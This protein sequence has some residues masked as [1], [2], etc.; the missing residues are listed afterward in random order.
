M[1]RIPLVVVGAGVAGAAAAIEAAKAGVQVT[2]IDENPIDMYM[3]A[4]DAPQFFG[5]R[6]MPTLR[7]KAVMLERIVSSN[8]ELSR[9]QEAGVDVRLG[10]YVWGSFR[11]IET[12]RLLD[13]PQL[14]LADGERS[15][16]IG[17]DR[18]IV[19]SGSRDLG[20]SF[21]GWN[22]A[23]VMGANGAHLLMTRYQALTSRRMVVLGSGNLGLSTAKMA[24]DR[25]VHVVAVVDIASSVQG[26]DALREE[27]ERKGVDFYTS[28]VIKEA[29]GSTDE[30]ESVVLVEADGDNWPVAGRE[31]ELACDTVCLAIGLV[32]NVELLDLLDCELTFDSKLGG[33]APK[34]DDW[35][36][37][38]VD[39]VFVAGDA[40][41]WYEGMIGRPE[42]ALHQGRLAGIAAAMSLGAIDSTTAHA[43]RAELQTTWPSVSASDAYS[44][45]NKWL[46]A[47]VNTGG[48]DVFACQCEEVTRREL[49]DV[50][51]PRYLE[52]DSERM[53]SRN[54]KT[55]LQDGPVN[56]EQIKRLTRVAMGHCQGRRC[57][58]QVAMLLAQHSNTDI[59]EVPPMSYRPPVRPLPLRVMWA[60]E[61]P[62]KMRD[63]WVVWFK[64]MEEYLKQAAGQ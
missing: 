35:M 62:Q 4:W 53:S 63:E 3:M 25:G 49:I 18:L 2:L 1:E 9:A 54:L 44:G 23:G 20:M 64:T 31:K 33:F 6:L 43:G 58:E 16:V 42:I 22:M 26:S 38:S 24:T 60:H 40:A 57:R 12:S 55:L 13:G 48:L 59:A 30:I 36:R 5:Q 34:V 28:H 56:P 14:G 17:Y 29:R 61:E 45:W 19:A 41:G 52:W 7:N 8:E 21:Q 47:L 15:W 51:P 32:P 50:R 46:S 37:T 39:T 10:T 27:L 11:N